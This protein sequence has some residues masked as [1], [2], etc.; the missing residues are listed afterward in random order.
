VSGP[1]DPLD[2]GLPDGIVGLFTTRYGGVSTGGWAELNL[3]QHVEDEARRVLANRDLLAD[4]V[5]AGWVNVPQQIHGAGVLVV[6]ATRAG[7]RRI[8]R[9]GARGVDALV[10][11]ERMTPIGV[12]VADCLPVLIA[13]PRQGVVAAAHAGRRGLA[14][15][16]L[17][18]TL[19]S[20]ESSGAQ[21]ADCIAVIGPAVCGRCYEVPAE[22]RDEVDA[23]VPGSAATTRRGTPSLDLAA[24]AE[25]VLRR[26]GLGDVRQSGICTVEDERFYSY[27]RDGITGRF[28]GVVMLGDR[29]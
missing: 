16:I 13:D 1:I 2:A 17:Q 5:G 20:M 18:A 8:I 25:Q 11:R 12:L 6:D 23:R 10:T 3:G 4:H 28:A 29:D 22:M 21:I 15:G 24:G 27:R 14:A 7:R 9:G 26:A 19:E